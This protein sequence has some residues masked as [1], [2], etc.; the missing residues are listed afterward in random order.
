MS[1]AAS[2]LEGAAERAGLGQQSSNA[3][4][5]LWRGAA[6]TRG[7][8]GG[9]GERGLL[10]RRL[11]AEGTRDPGHTPG[12]LEWHW[13]PQDGTRALVKP[14]RPSG[15]HRASEP[16]LHPCAAKDCPLWAPGAAPRTGR[17]VHGP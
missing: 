7:T 6:A 1:L 8:G 15:W 4:R 9:L 5:E 3:G 17:P 13:D 11:W 12:L 10:G 16:R 2:E 14:P